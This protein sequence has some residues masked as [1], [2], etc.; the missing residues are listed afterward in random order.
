MRGPDDGAGRD[1]GL[2]DRADR[3][4][5]VR[6]AVADPFELRGVQARQF[7]NDNAHAAAVMQ[8]FATD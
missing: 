6:H 7:D 5:G 4:G 1:F 8:E 2:V 3:L